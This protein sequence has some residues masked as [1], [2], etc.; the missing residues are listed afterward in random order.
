MAIRLLHHEV[1]AAGHEIDIPSFHPGHPASQNVVPTHKTGY[2]LRARLAID[3]LWGAGLINATVVHHH[4]QIGQCHR[5]FLAV[6]DLDKRD[7]EFG[8]QTFELDSHLHPQEWIQ[9]GEGL[10]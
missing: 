5:F 9:S 6:R 10:V 4:H 8:L 3:L 7:A 1:V 2:K